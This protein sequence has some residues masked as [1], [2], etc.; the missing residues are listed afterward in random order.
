MSI[1]GAGSGWDVW[2]AKCTSRPFAAAFPW[3]HLRDLCG[4][5]GWGRQPFLH[6]PRRERQGIAAGSCLHLNIYD[7]GSLAAPHPPRVDFVLPSGIADKHCSFSSPWQGWQ[8]GWAWTRAS[9][10]CKATSEVPQ[11]G[12]KG[13]LP[14]LEIPTSLSSL[15]AAPGLCVLP[16]EGIGAGGASR[17]VQAAWVGK[18]SSG[19]GL[20]AAALGK[21]LG[22][23]LDSL[24]PVPPQ[25]QLGRCSLLHPP[26]L[27]EIH[28][29]SRVSAA[30]GGLPGG[31]EA[32]KAPGGGR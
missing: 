30:L 5:L 23:A 1:P 12:D 4:V 27:R 31:P 28:L 16:S 17:G 22:Q 2:F 32:A 19:E 3:G 26:P 15:P 7:P 13:L 14:A 8:L 9:L 20:G 29:P 6:Q 24:S 10:L 25:A 18:I 11:G 21:W